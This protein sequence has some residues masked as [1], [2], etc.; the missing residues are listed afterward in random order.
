MEDNDKL[1]SLAPSTNAEF[2]EKYENYFYKALV[3]EDDSIKLHN[4]NIA[5][6]GEYGAGKSSM[7]KSF[8]CKYKDF[9][10]INVTLGS[11][12]EKPDYSESDIEYSILQQIIYTE[13]PNKLPLSRLDRIDDKNKILEE[14]AFKISIY[15]IY[16][17]LSIF[18]L[19]N[20]N[21]ITN[22]N[23]IGIAISI[24]M[25]SV[26]VLL[27]SSFLLIYEL[28]RSK[29]FNKIAFKIFG[30]DI[31]LNK[32][33]DKSVLN[34]NIEEL[35][36][37]FINTKY[38]II[39]F[40]DIDRLDNPERIFGK[41]KEINH[42][43]NNSITNK[44]IQF[45]YSVG[46]K[47]FSN[48][49]KRV[50][51]FDIIIPIIAYVGYGNNK[52]KLE[53]CL[54]QNKLFVKANKINEDIEEDIEYICQFINDGRKIY[55][56][57]NEF[58]IY[59]RKNLDDISRRKLLYLISY[60]IIY[61]E[62]YQNLIDNEGAIN[63]YYSETFEQKSK[64]IYV[65]K[66][67]EELNN[68]QGNQLPEDN[69]R[70]ANI[71]AILKNIETH[72]ID[73]DEKIEILRALINSKT[74]TKII[75][76]KQEL[77]KFEEYMIRNELINNTF[78][79]LIVCINDDGNIII[80]SDLT[81]IERI[82]ANLSIDGYKIFD[83]S[84]VFKY[85]S[86]YDFGN[87]NTLHKDLYKE[88]L[89]STKKNR[90]LKIIFKNIDLEKIKFML[91]LEKDNIKILKESKDFFS[92]IWEYISNNKLDEELINGLI[93]YTFLYSNP[94][95]MN[96]D[97][98]FII[99]ASTMENSISFLEKK[100]PNTELSSNIKNYSF[101][102][103]KDVAFS[104]KTPEMLKIISKN[105]MYHKVS[106]HIVPISKA[107][108]YNYDE[109]RIIKSLMDF[110]ENNSIR[111]Y[112]LEDVSDT[113]NSYIIKLNFN[114][115]D[116]EISLLKLISDYEIQPEDFSNLLI[117]EEIDIENIESFGNYENI[118]INR[119]KV[120]A[121]WKN[122]AR[123]FEKNNNTINTD[124]VEIINNKY[125]VLKDKTLDIINN[126][127]NDCFILNLDISEE[128]YRHLIRIIWNNNNTKSI[129]NIPVRN[130]KI[131][132][133]EDLYKITT[134][135]DLDSVINWEI[136]DYYKVK[137]INS[138]I[139]L[140][141]NYSFNRA[142]SELMKKIIKDIKNPIITNQLI[143]NYNNR[144][145]LKEEYYELISINKLKI[146]SDQVIFAMNNDPKTNLTLLE[147]YKEF[148]NDSNIYEALLRIIPNKAKEI[149]DTNFLIKFEYNTFNERILNI[150]KEKGFIR[151]YNKIKNQ[152]Y[153]SIKRIKKNMKQ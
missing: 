30:G 131:I 48:S 58:K 135:N 76:G 80:D 54:I 63:Y 43:L 50:K 102:Y 9:K 94:K 100:M 37:F 95:D 118:I 140:V 66:L 125:S 104:N 83:S 130:A 4:K 57:V 126:T 60:K 20:Y 123:L 120:G 88:M 12:S 139:E 128:A 31:E 103:S 35:I 112:L 85:L 93:Y 151:D 3:E 42:I 106:N 15:I 109:K 98:T 36:N 91:D 17:L 21:S 81:V 137:I 24:I 132:I 22:V 89:K 45:V 133:D 8:F 147:R 78:R 69:S 49:E 73:I 1:Y 129:V 97:K 6:M 152:N 55:D 28:L 105:R 38:S 79:Y 47:V 39:I 127:F 5:I 122:I 150:M 144:T 87:N 64:E 86:I 59:N 101:K 53:E 16:I 141:I 70:K 92:Q 41:L 68:L 46:N 116:D 27:V 153:Y 56:L 23:S 32:K 34:A 142:N 11:Y 124:I 71:Q 13:R 113:I 149:K 67:R 29:I 52:A 14:E 19:K 90:I 136:E 111:E 115:I 77:N 138:S 18:T 7:I 25:F 61:P 51:F 62:N 107:L 40:E 134:Q 65:T 117:K 145:D 119:K 44:T 82:K 108:N 121:T 143:W 72:K 26:F 96:N 146:T 75:T 99:Y 33:E 110:P 2:L 10:A 74:N 114:Q 84:I 148:F